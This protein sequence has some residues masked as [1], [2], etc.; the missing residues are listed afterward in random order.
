MS[1]IIFSTK[2][3]VLP[4]EPIYEHL[5]HFT[6]KDSNEIEQKT[7]PEQVYSASIKDNLLELKICLNEGLISALLSEG[8]A[9]KKISIQ[10]H[11]KK[12]KILFTVDYNVNYRTF[13][14]IDGNYESTKL[15]ELTLYYQIVDM[16]LSEIVNEELKVVRLK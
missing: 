9:S 2:P 11:D 13:T 7:L 10:Y 4:L 1:T 8:I 6:A 15:M 5:F 12:G 16:Y 3:S 14:G